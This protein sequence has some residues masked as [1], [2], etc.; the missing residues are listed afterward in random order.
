MQRL[1]TVPATYL[2]FTFTCM[3]IGTVVFFL[4][5]MA[6]AEPRLFVLVAT[7]VVAA[8][9]VVRMEVRSHRRARKLSVKKSGLASDLQES[10]AQMMAVAQATDFVM[11]SLKSEPADQIA[12]FWLTEWM[13]NQDGQFSPDYNALANRPGASGDMEIATARA[14]VR[15][16]RNEIMKYGLLPL[17]VTRLS[18]FELLQ[19]VHIPPELPRWSSAAEPSQDDI[20]RK[21]HI[22]SIVFAQQK[23]VTLSAPQILDIER[24]LRPLLLFKRAEVIGPHIDLK[25]DL[26]NNPR[27]S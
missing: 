13:I 24:A 25:A 19:S 23:S 16:H 8:F 4:A 11:S 10:F 14:L 15:L 6:L 20:L 5:A 26:K 18:T 9:F 12:S 3:L 1:L 7:L 22:I 27:R 17:Y 21:S 2:K